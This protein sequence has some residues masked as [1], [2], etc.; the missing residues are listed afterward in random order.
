MVACGAVG[1]VHATPFGIAAVSFRFHWSV[2]DLE[3]RLPRH[4]Q[5]AGRLLRQPGVD[6][7]PGVQFL[8]EDVVDEHLFVLADPGVEA[9][10]QIF[11]V[12]VADD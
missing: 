8:L 5:R 6:V 10:D 12:I 2:S 1:G 4:Q 7:S 11:L 3:C 9:M